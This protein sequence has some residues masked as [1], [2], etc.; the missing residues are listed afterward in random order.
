[1][2]FAIIVLFFT[3]FVSALPIIGQVQLGR[4][5]CREMALEYSHQVKLSENQKEQAL[6]GKKIARAGHLP[7]FNA[8]GFYFYKPDAL[9]YSLEGGP[10]PTYTPD[11]QGELQPNIKKNPITDMPIMG[12][13]GN[14][15]FNM[16]A[17]MPD[18]N[19]N[20]GL[21]GVT[22]AGI[23]IEQPVYMGGKIR[24]ANKMA[25]TG[26]D[27]AK[28]NTEVKT[29]EVIEETD[30]VFLKY[31]TVKAKN[32]AAR[33]YKTM[34]DS[35][36]STINASLEEGLA[37]RNDLL[38][39]KVKRNEALLMVQ[40]AESG[41]KLARMNLCRVIGLPL[42]TNI[43]VNE[44]LSL[45]ESDDLKP[46]EKDNSPVQRPEFKILNKA[47]KLGQQ[48]EKMKRSG[49]LPQVG[50]S[51]GYNYFGGLELNDQG[52]DEMSFSAMAS[53]K[54]PI[55]NW[56][57]QRNKVSKARLQT[58]AAQMNLEETEKLIQLEIA[59]ARLNLQDAITRIELTKISMEQAKENLETSQEQYNNGMERLVDLLEA[60][61]QW[62]ESQSDHIDAQANVKLM[63]TKYLKATGQLLTD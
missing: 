21:E 62:Q 2:K 4:D 17:M 55:F 11:E 47:I 15:V 32:K 12:P 29:T 60:Q 13:D 49:M 37:T 26:I 28:L 7:N 34:L 53:V 14:P 19:L 43:T 33:D 8:S 18:I 61:A 40:K 1:M 23:S 50:L 45:E 39:A 57:E 22:M 27:M 54:I 10:L 16:Y 20:L 35:L 51:A 38:K 3:L 58:E 59:R 52:T 56:F 46:G 36:V 5:K 31:I 24:A 25:E 42:E 63:Q 48:E 6:L 30:A 41:Q 44:S 9:E